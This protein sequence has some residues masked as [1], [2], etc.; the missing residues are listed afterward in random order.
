MGQNNKRG[1]C[2]DPGPSLGAMTFQMMFNRPLG[3]ILAS[4]LSIRWLS[5][6]TVHAVPPISFTQNVLSR[7]WQAVIGSA[8]VGFGLGYGMMAALHWTRMQAI[9]TLLSYKGWLFSPRDTSTKVGEPL[10][11]GHVTCVDGAF[12]KIFL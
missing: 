6:Y 9:A 10:C 12:K 2:K 4:A 1:S 5:P 3:G 11:G 7:K 8:I